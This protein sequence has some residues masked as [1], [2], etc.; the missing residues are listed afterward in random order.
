MTNEYDLGIPPELMARYLASLP[1]KGR[2]LQESWEAWRSSPGPVPLAHLREVLHRLA[3]ST[4]MYGFDS[5]GRILRVPLRLA[6]QLLDEA[7]SDA[8]LEQ[9]LQVS[10]LQLL[11]QWSL[12]CESL[13]PA[14]ADD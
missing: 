9:E 1:E 2:Q 3:G 6:D 5:L 7:P 12:I 4:L 13:D 11:D 8:Q 10:M 14:L